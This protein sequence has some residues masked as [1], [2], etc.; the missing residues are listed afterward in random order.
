LFLSLNK[1]TTK[2]K[3]KI[4]ATLIYQI[5]TVVFEEERDW[6]ITGEEQHNNKKANANQFLRW[7]LKTKK[8][9]KS[10]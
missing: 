1:Y 8:N 10:I 4:A 9:P 6:E 5:I 7:S 2:G 3:S